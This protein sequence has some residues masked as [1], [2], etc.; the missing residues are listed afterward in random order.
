MHQPGWHTPRRQLVPECPD[1]YL[2]AHAGSGGHDG[3]MLGAGFVNSSVMPSIRSA[4]KDLPWGPVPWALAMGLV[5]AGATSGSIQRSADPRAA[6]VAALGDV[7]LIASVEGVTL[8]DDPSSFESTRGVVR[9]WRRDEPA[10]VYL[11]KAKIAPSGAVIGE[12]ALYNLTNTPADEG[13]IVSDGHIFLFPVRSNT[14]TIGIRTLDIRGEGSLEGDWS[15]KAR[16]QNAITNI[17]QTGQSPGVRSAFWTVDPPTDVELTLTKDKWVEVSVNDAVARM[18]AE[19]GFPIGNLTII[20]YQPS[21]KAKPGNL[22]TWSVDRVRAM[23]WFGDD[24]MQM[25]KAV[26]FGALDVYRR[27][28]TSMLGDHTAEEIA[29]DLGDIASRNPPTTFTDPETG[30]PPPPIEPFMSKPIE[31]EGQWIALEND[32][33][34]RRNPGVPAA[35]LTSFVRT[36]RKRSYTRIYITL[37]DPRQVEMHMMA[38]SVEPKGASGQAGPGMIPRSPELMKRLVAALNGGFQALHG[39]FGMMSDGVIYLPPKPYAATVA[40]MR[41]GTT[42]FGTWPN[43][44]VVPPTIRSY[45]QNLTPLV[46]DGQINPYKRGWWGGTPPEWEDRVT[47]TRTGI[48]LTQENFVAYFYGNEIDV[49]PLAQA[50]VQAR[51]KYGLHLDMN[52]GHTGL[53]FYTVAPTGTLPDFGRP[54][55]RKWE[56]EGPVPFMDGWTF[57]ARR[58]VRFM[59]LMNFPRYIQREAR[60]YFY[61]TLRPVLPGYD[62]ELEGA[63][64]EEG[65]WRTTGLPQHGFPYAVATTQARPDASRPDAKAL[66]VKIDPR[67]IR[68]ETNATQNVVVSL[69]NANAVAGQL[70]LWLT[71]RTAVISAAPIAGGVPVVSG[72]AADASDAANAVAAVGVQDDDG[73]LVYI[74]VQEGRRPGADAAL[75][76]SLLDKVGCSSKVMLARPLLPTFGDQPGPRAERVVQLVRVQAPG[77]GR[78]FESTPVVDPNEWAPLQAKRIRYFKKPKKKDDSEP[79]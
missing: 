23:P 22:V 50:M 45:R 20:E 73:M 7:G 10:D 3:K 61:L 5:A 57:R 54:F 56:E 8:L 51:C 53:E 42:G 66:L 68:M 75:L 30:W 2:P 55:D 43:D 18:P 49:M 34:I 13:P 67:T 62:L 31:G 41:D 29:E 19:G 46:M 24:K 21:V 79:E 6:I 37:W 4:L 28:E 70:T 60:D 40:Q 58:M 52:P 71:E 77:A 74:E 25:I 78:I 64:D 14:G 27:T 17:Q 32:P 39:E 63:K 48:C 36:D 11:F 1:P 26:A 38:G 35:F 65:K 16:A 15:T 9:A 76:S 12:P 69:S 47:S 72:H 59:G 44:P 33:F